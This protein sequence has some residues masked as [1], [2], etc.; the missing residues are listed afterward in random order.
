GG[1]AA[2][3]APLEQL[4]VRD[5][6]RC[7]FVPLREVSVISSEGNYV[8]LLWGRERPLLARSLAALEQKLDAKRF[9]RANRRQ[10]INLEFIAQVE[11]GDGGRLHV[12]MRDGPEI[13][14]SRRQARLF[15]SLS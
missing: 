2:P 15:R 11:L 9:F 14:I 12:Q 1:A 4:F 3:G 6:H 7:W 8:R 5:G 13:E 10:L